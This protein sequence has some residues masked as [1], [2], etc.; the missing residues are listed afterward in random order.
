M[1][2]AV[3]RNTASLTRENIPHS[4]ATAAPQAN[5]YSVTLPATVVFTP[6]S[7]IAINQGALFAGTAAARPGRARKGAQG[8]ETGTTGRRVGKG[9]QG[10]KITVQWSRHSHR[11]KVNK[12]HD[13][14]VAYLSRRSA[15]RAIPSRVTCRAIRLP[16]PPASRLPRKCNLRAFLSLHGPCGR[17]R[18]LTAKEILI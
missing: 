17:D 5:K 1:V 16:R 2:E 10:A 12:C 11:Y 13:A 8:G 14:W 7:L 18:N 9:G 6:I 4:L 3:F 15:R